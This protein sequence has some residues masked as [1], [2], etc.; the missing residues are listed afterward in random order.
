MNHQPQPADW[1]LRNSAPPL[2]AAAAIRL[3]LLTA[4]LLRSGAAALTRPDT[5]SYLLPGRNLLLHGAFATNGLPE[6]LRTPGY[7]LFLALATLTGP[8]AASLIQILLSVLSVA[9]VARLASQV[10]ATGPTAGGSA[11]QW[12]TAAVRSPR[13]RQLAPPQ[14]AQAA[15]G[16]TA[17]GAGAAWIFAFEPLSVLYSILLLPETLFL[18]LFLLS[19]E[20][21]TQFLRTQNLRTLAFAGLALAAA[22]FVRP[23]TYYLPIPLALGLSFALRHAPSLRVKAPAVLLLT[24]LP[25]LALWQLRNRIETGFPGFSAIP[26][27]NLYFYTAAEVTGRLQHQSLAEVQNQLGYTSDQNFLA[28][29]PESARWTQSQRIA[30]MQAAALCTLRSH[31]ATALHAYLAGS[32]RTAFNPGAAVLLSLFNAPIHESVFARERDQG[33][34]SAWLWLARDHP[35]QTALMAAFTIFLAALYAFAV[36][37]AIRSP[38]PRSTLCLLLGVSLYF[39]AVSGGAAGIARLRLPVMPVLC[40]LAA[41][42]LPRKKPAR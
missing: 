19:L 9:L 6:L 18:F 23:V 20:R 39:L 14:V 42:G 29:H 8:I 38:A 36:C 12:D 21:L 11:A 37:G 41:A 25:W 2:L 1:N 32:L 34:L 10:F 33:P 16:P 3:A 4:V 28:L 26:T 31:P 27:Q 22:T 24:V 35:L 7:P 5:Q 13:R 30:F 15:I 17:G 40:V